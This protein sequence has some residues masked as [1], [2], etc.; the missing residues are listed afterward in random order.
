MSNDGFV[1]PDTDVAAV[2]NYFETAHYLDSALQEFFQY[3]K[4]SGIYNNS[5][6]VLYGDHY[7]LSNSQN[8]ALAPLLGANADDWNDFDNTQ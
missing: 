4:D 3:L 2:N 8:T 7:G 1:K 6:I 5:M